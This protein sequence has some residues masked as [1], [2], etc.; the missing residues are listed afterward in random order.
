M[1]TPESPGG[2]ELGKQ[3]AAVG[4]ALGWEE[5]GK[6]D[7]FTLGEKGPQKRSHAAQ[8]T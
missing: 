4:V 3:A 1:S 2:S 7:A 6:E 8:T 5:D